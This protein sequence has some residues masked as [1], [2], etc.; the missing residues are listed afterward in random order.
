MKCHSVTLSLF[1]E[2]YSHSLITAFSQPT[3]PVL[4]KICAEICAEICDEN[5]TTIY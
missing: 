5:S 1:D 2:N 3:I 4:V